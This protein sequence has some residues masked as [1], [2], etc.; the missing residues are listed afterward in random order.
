LVIFDPNTVAANAEYGAPY[1]PPTGIHWVL[2][3]GQI[4]VRQGNLVPEVFPGNRL[5][6]SRARD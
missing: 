1:L 5:G 3:N 6:V 4:V 2:V